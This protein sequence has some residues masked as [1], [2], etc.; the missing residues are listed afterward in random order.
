[1]EACRAAPSCVATEVIVQSKLACGASVI[2]S[3]LKVRVP[4]RHVEKR[5]SIVTNDAFEVTCG[6]GPAH[7]CKSRSF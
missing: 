2:V 3:C 7:T 1:M 5:I 4:G 6:Q